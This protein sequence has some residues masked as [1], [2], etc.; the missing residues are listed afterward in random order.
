M[1]KFLFRVFFVGISLLPL[2]ASA[3]ESSWAAAEQVRARIISSSDQA[4][5][6][7][8]LSPGW[9]S[10][11]RVPGDAGL[12]PRFDWS[13]SSNVS[14]VDVKWPVP[15]RMDEA[16]FVTFGYEGTYSL[17]LTVQK[18]NPQDVAKLDLALDIMVCKEIC[19]PQ[20][21]KLSLDMDGAASDHASAIESAL[22]NIPKTDGPITIDNVVNG[23]DAV[24][25]TAT[26]R[27]NFSEVDAFITVGET[28]FTAKPVVM[29]DDKDPHKVMVTIAKPA[30]A[31][32]LTGKDVN[33]VLVSGDQAAEKNVK[34]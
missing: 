1:S 9:H 34:F 8:E 32:N 12:P 25:V 15:R 33:V 28:V 16:G 4:V 5:L 2:P 31:A 10:Y 18:A 17:P 21:L 30:S 26:S 7:I 24:V 11:W 23:P 19:I 22:R 14:G 29:P 20:Q 6:D 27:N 3:A 13:K